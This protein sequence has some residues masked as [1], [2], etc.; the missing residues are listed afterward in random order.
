MSGTNPLPAGQAAIIP[1]LGAGTLGPGNGGAQP[2]QAGTP[3]RPLRGPPAA[4]VRQPDLGSP[5]RVSVLTGFGAGSGA[6][7]LSSGSDADQSQ[8][9]VGI[10]VGLNPLGSGTLGLTFPAGITTGQY[11]F[12]ADWATGNA[13]PPSGNNINVTWTATRPLVSG[14]LLLVA[15]QWAASN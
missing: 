9:L 7:I 6:G 1:P 5:P 4:F 10:R 2:G 12:L 8:G 14:E 13:A 15:Y 3:L 11:V